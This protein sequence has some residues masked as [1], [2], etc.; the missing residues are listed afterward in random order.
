MLMLKIQGFSQSP[1]SSRPS[2]CGAG[3][4]DGPLDP[5]IPC[6]AAS[7]AAL[8]LQACRD[9][10]VPVSSPPKSFTGAL[11]LSHLYMLRAISQGGATA[12]LFLVSTG[13]PPLS[14]VPHAACRLLCH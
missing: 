11:S 6:R 13:S 2:T 1:A 10:T 8:D 12:L 5:G 7:P 14:S 9:A 3:P 4:L